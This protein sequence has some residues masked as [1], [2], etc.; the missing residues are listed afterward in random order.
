MVVCGVWV[1]YRC[2]LRR[3]DTVCE[4]I[5]QWRSEP[6]APGTWAQTV[7][8]SFGEHHGEH[9]YVQYMRPWM[10]Y[11]LYHVRC[12]VNHIHTYKYT[13]EILEAFLSV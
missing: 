8:L 12:Y 6:G 1:T 10:A 4:A 3:C 2:D 5:L 13:C 11:M 9:A 7:A